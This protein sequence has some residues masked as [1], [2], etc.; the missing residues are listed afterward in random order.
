MVLFLV[1]LSQAPT[2]LLH[3][4]TL[5]S[6]SL[7]PHLPLSLSHTY[8][9]LSPPLPLPLSPPLLM[10]KYMYM[11]MIFFLKCLSI[12]HVHIYT[13]NYTCTCTLYV[14]YTCTLYV[15]ELQREKMQVDSLQS[16]LS[17]MK[18][19]EVTE[20]EQRQTK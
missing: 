12:Y 3:T 14:H 17:R 16:S 11:Y 2:S 18:S 10:Y 20:Q 9:S 19:A 8:T 7:S 15:Q 4:R 13:C 1:F 5:L 6:P